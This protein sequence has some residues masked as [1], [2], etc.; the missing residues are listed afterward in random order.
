MLIVAGQLLGLVSTLPFTGNVHLLLAINQLRLAEPLNTDIAF[1][2]HKGDL[3]EALQ[4]PLLLKTDI[5]VEPYLQ[6]P[7]LVVSYIW[8][9]VGAFNVGNTQD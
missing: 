3:S 8:L 2:L 9:N 7:G 5:S 1:V 4:P 6:E